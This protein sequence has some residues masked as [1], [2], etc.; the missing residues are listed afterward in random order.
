MK[1]FEKTGT[2]INLTVIGTVSNNLDL[3]SLPIKHIE[4]GL[5]VKSR[6]SND[7]VLKVNSILSNSTLR[8]KIGISAQS[9]IFNNYRW[10]YYAINFKIFILDF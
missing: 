2:R 7:F 5:V 10:G 9:L 4:N 1:L 6:I 8:R 3:S